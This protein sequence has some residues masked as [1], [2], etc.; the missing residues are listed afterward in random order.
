MLSLHAIPDR[1]VPLLQ[2][3]A[4]QTKINSPLDKTITHLLK[5]LKSNTT[6][7]KMQ[8]QFFAFLEK[9]YDLKSNKSKLRDFDL[10]RF[11]TKTDR[12][13]ADLYRKHTTGENHQ[14]N[15]LGTELVVIA[16]E[17]RGTS[18]TVYSRSS[19]TLPVYPVH[20][21]PP[22]PPAMNPIF[23]EYI[24]NQV[25]QALDKVAQQNLK[26]APL[27]K[28]IKNYLQNP[29]EDKEIRQK[30]YQFLDREYKL[31]A[32][33]KKQEKFR[34]YEKEQLAKKIDHFLS[35]LY[36]A[37]LEEEG[38]PNST[39]YI[40]RTFNEILRDASYINQVYNVLCT[41]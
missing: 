28:E 17:A 9:Q 39:E 25:I 13:I 7:Q 20:A 38:N 2:E 41:T 19:D 31:T 26:A 30:F 32:P 5:A 33:S 6:V 3:F 15:L 35:I 27:L 1:V 21:A 29:K 24:P 40:S 4:L 34:A 11:R 12:F 18:R 22:P 16:E 36:Q 37:H 8:E 23:I 14:L 10:N